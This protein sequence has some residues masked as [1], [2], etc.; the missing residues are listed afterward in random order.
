[1]QRD[2]GHLPRRAAHLRAATTPGPGPWGLPG[3]GYSYMGA[4]TV[5]G[6]H[7]PFPTT[8]G[9]VVAGVQNM[10]AYSLHSYG[11]TGYGLMQLGNGTAAS[12]CLQ[13]K[14]FRCDIQN[15][16]EPVKTSCRGS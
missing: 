3:D 5:A 11:K 12:I 10:N 2:H 8:G 13:N 4:A 7:T 15:A 6:E 1:M 14:R 16:Y 9:A